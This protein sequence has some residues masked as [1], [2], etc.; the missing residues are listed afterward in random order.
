MEQITSKYIYPIS[1][2]LLGFPVIRV[3]MAK[4]VHADVV[5]QILLRSEVKDLIRFKSVCKSW[6][7]LI[8]SHR[9]VNRHLKHSYN[10]DRI[11]NEIG[12]RRV[13]YVDD[14]QDDN[15]LVGSSNGLVCIISFCGFE[16]SVVN[17]M[18]GEVTRLI[19]PPPYMGFLLCWF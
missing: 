11:D 8:T 5:E 19:R 15:E 18:T 10:K 9:F 3:S 14:D 4:F 12:H 1:S 6:H 17:P 2:T 16:F 7:S 13:T